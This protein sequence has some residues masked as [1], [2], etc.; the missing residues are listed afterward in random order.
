MRIEL[1]VPNPKSTIYPGMFARVELGV[2][3]RPQALVIPSK[4]VTILQNHSFVFVNLGGTARKVPVTV[5]TAD[6]DWCEACSGLTGEDSSSFRRGKPVTDGMAV[7]TGGARH[8]N[9]A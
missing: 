2:E 5:G 3:R 1:D 7:T 4:A 6:G 9:P 8:E